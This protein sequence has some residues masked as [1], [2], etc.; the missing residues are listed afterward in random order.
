MTVLFLGPPV[1]SFSLHL[2]SQ[3]IIVNVDYLK[4]FCS[5]LP[6]ERVEIFG[7]HM[8]WFL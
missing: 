6:A 8:V 7:P 3:L 2:L 1:S 4:G 5:Y